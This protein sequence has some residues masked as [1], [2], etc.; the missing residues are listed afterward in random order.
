[1]ILLGFVLACGE[2][3]VTR[4]DAASG[5]LVPVSELGRDRRRMTIEQLSVSLKEVSGGLQWEDD[6]EEDQLVQLSATLGVPDY[7]EITD[8]V[9]EPSLL[10]HRFL[11]E[12]ANTICLELV[13]VDALRPD[14]ERVFFVEAEATQ[15]AMASTQA[16]LRYLLLR[17][18]GHDHA[19]D[20]A[21]IERWT[22]LFMMTLD[23]TNGD[24]KSAW[25][26]VC[27]ALTTHPDFY[28]F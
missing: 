8:E 3:E 4:K 13:E 9:L 20:S 12:A 1:M 18:H 28:A 22:D 25:R 7:I 5:D 19:E 14:E 26:T 2:P 15:T 21:E 16:N 6:R 23:A 11:D 17:F 10:F 24:P 27:V